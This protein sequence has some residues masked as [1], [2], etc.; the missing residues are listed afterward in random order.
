MVKTVCLSRREQYA[1]IEALATDIS[2]T[3]IFADRIEIS[4]VLLCF[5]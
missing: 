1:Y 2:Y 3:A 4:L 5:S